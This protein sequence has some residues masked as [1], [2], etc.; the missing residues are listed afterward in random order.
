MRTFK[1]S[2]VSAIVLNLFCFAAVPLSAQSRGLE[3]IRAADMKVHLDF[4]AAPQFQGRPAPSAEVEIA[5]LYLAR[6]AENEAAT[7]KDKYLQAGDIAERHRDDNTLLR[8]ELE[9]YRR[10][11][12]ELGKPLGEWE[13]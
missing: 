5:S 12:E 13:E 1:A 9:W 7:W 10:R 8:H 11:N 3:A 4:L 6:E 2:A